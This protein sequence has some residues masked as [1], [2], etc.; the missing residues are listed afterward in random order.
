MVTVSYCRV[1]YSLNQLSYDFGTLQKSLSFGSRSG[2]SKVVQADDP[3]G[4]IRSALRAAL[5]DTDGLVK[6]QAQ[7][8]QTGFLHGSS[9]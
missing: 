4:Y 3:V 8:L 1:A 9:V 5:P 6:K 7:F 2:C